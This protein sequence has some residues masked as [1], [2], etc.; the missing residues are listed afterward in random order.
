M[1]QTPAGSTVSAKSSLKS[2]CV[3]SS[4]TNSDSPDD[5]AVLS[6]DA[7]LRFQFVFPTLISIAKIVTA[8]FEKIKKS[9]ACG[10]SLT[11]DPAGIEELAE[12]CSGVLLQPRVKTFMKDY[13]Q[14]MKLDNGNNAPMSPPFATP[15]EESSSAEQLAWNS[16]RGSG[17]SHL[18]SNSCNSPTPREAYF[19]PEGA[20]DEVQSVSESMFEDAVEP[21]EVSQPSEEPLQVKSAPP[22]LDPKL[23]WNALS[24]EEYEMI[25]QKL[26]ED[27]FMTMMPDER[28]NIHYNTFGYST[29]EWRVRGPEYLT[30]KKKIVSPPS[31]GEHLLTDAVHCTEEIVCYGRHP[32]GWVRELR[33]R[34]EQRFLFIINFRFAPLHVVILISQVSSGVHLWV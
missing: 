23:N 1:N 34:G 18:D 22:V 14:L 33:R 30:N 17:L 27:E 11:P 10:V 7:W 25:F 13:E 19:P 3:R 21:E 5:G 24:K 28:L 31:L 15:T 26:K 16:S 8:D 2:A 4:G 12:W 20:E 6:S 9:P 32:E 29:T